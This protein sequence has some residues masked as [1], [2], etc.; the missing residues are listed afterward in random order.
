V[1]ET[2]LQGLLHRIRVSSPLV[3]LLVL[4]LNLLLVGAALLRYCPELVVTACLA[5]KWHV[6]ATTGIVIL[7][8][9]LFLSTLELYL[10]SGLNLCVRRQQDVADGKRVI[11]SLSGDHKRILRQ[12][13]SRPR[14]GLDVGD[15]NAAALLTDLEDWGLIECTDRVFG[16]YRIDFVWSE[17]IGQHPE[18]LD[19]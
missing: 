8:P 12:L 16:T 19:A 14:H 1:L 7:I 4:C 11:R 2:L 18:L 17:F 13:M 5:D 6:L 10:L 3:V 9:A 15:P